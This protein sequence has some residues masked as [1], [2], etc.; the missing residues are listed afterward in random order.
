MAFL[1]RKKHNAMVFGPEQKKMKPRHY[2][3]YKHINISI[4]HPQ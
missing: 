1:T 3:T 4:P 2:D